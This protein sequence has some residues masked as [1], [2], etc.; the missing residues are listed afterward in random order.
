MT[1]VCAACG[2]KSPASPDAAQSTAV[3]P[4]PAT[5][6]GTPTVAA[7][8][9]AGP[10]IG[11]QGDAPDGGV[12]AVAD[13]PSAA[14]E[15]SALVDDAEPAGETAVAVPLPADLPVVPGLAPEVVARALSGAP[16]C[17]GIAKSGRAVL[18]IIEAEVDGAKARE[19]RFTD[20]ATPDRQYKDQGLW[21]FAACS[22]E[23][24]AEPM[25]AIVMAEEIAELVKPHRLIACHDTLGAAD[26]NV[27]AKSVPIT[28]AS[29]DDTLSVAIEGS[30]PVV[31]AKSGDLADVTFET[32]YWADDVGAVFV[33]AADPNSGFDGSRLIAIGATELGDS[34]CVPRPNGPQRYDFEPMPAFDPKP[35]SPSCVA[36]TPD[37]KMAAFKIFRT[38]EGATPNEVVWFG[39]GTAPALD[40]RCLVRGCQQPERDAMAAAAAQ[41]G[42]IGC[43]EARGTVGIDG[44]ATPWMYKGNEVK[45]K[46]AS[47]WRVVHRLAM[48]AH[49]G[50]DH[51][52]LWKVFQ[53][54]GSGPIFLYIGNAD[55]GF[56]ESRVTVLDDAKMNLCEVRQEEW[57]RVAEV[58]ASSAA[59]DASG[60]K[61]GAASVVDGDL[62]T[63]WQPAAGKAGDPPPWIELELVEEQDIAVVRIAN[64][65][66][67]KDGNGD[68]FAMNARAAEATLTFSDGE[69]EKVTFADERGWISI[70]IR[71]HRTKSVKIT[72]TALHAGSKWP[73]DVALSEVQLLVKP[74]EVP[75]P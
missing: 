28:V 26:V 57:R 17:V 44:W 9:D 22:G 66:Q 15:A 75:P 72:I 60:Y 67:R 65:F 61:F 70:R 46:T 34:P 16:G 25:R 24:C 30:A 48:S 36:M 37:G 20:T 69:T 55:T 31:F 53:F 21:R 19:L 73:G 7:A 11:G 41:A 18:S 39:A 54:L 5:T 32:A 58:H 3:P 47:G 49:D 14:P 38:G 33:R 62:T 1:V 8:S 42:L 35:A 6:V 23:A 64:G 74:L 40:L 27:I 4:L 50:G 10:G 68:M 43:H 2:S 52:Q 12:A 51:E 63:S 71:P 29:S 13:A 45:L 56:S 59:K